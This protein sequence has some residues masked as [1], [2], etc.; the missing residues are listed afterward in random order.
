MKNSVLRFFSM[1]LALSLVIGMFPMNVLAAPGETKPA[2]ES[3]AA[4]SEAA[5]PASDEEAASEGDTEI[6]FSMSEVAAT[7]LG[8]EEV[9]VDEDDPVIIAVETEL[10][11]MTVLND[12]GEAVKLTEEQIQNLLGLYQAYQQQWAEN[13]NVLGAQTPFFLQ[14]NDNGEDGLGA[15]GE[16]LVLSGWTVEE[17]RNGKYTYDDLNGMILNFYYG[18]L[19]GIQY[20][21]SAVESARDAA[22]AAVKNSGAETEAQKLLVLND[23]LAEV[24]TFD[25]PYIMNADAEDGEEPMQAQ[26]LQKH[27][28]EQDVYDT[29]YAVYE[30]SIR[31]QFEQQIKDGLKAEFK[32]QYYT[33]AIE[34]MAYEG[35]LA[36]IK[37]SDEVKNA[38]DA[39]LR[40]KAYDD[41]YAQETA[42]VYNEAEE[43][44]RLA[45]AAHTCE[46]SLDE[47]NTCTFCG[48]SVT[49]T[50]SEAMSVED[51]LET[52]S[53]QSKISAAGD[54]YRSLADTDAYTQARSEEHYE[55]Y[56]IYGDDKVADEY[57]T[58]EAAK[59]EN[60]KKDELTEDYEEHISAATNCDAE[61]ENGTCSVCGAGAVS[62]VIGDPVIDVDTYA[63]AEA[64]KAVENAAADI[65]AAAKKAQE[66]ATFTEEEVNAEI[67]KIVSGVS[68]D[69]TGEEVDEETAYESA[70]KEQA[71][72]YMTE[73]EEAIQKDP[74]AFVESNFGKEAAAQLAAG[75][76]A[77][78]AD[79]EENGVE[80]DPVSAPGYKMTVEE[81]VAQQMDTAMDDLGGMTPNEAIPVYAG[82]A[83]TQM[84]AGILNYWEGTQFGALAE[85][86]SVCLGYAK[87]YAYL[88]Q[89][90]HADY[91]TTDGN[92][93]KASSWKTAEELY[94]K[95]GELNI[96]AGYFVD[97]V[98]ISFDTDVTM[99]GETQENFNSDHFWNAVRVNGT[100]YYV[101]PCYTDVYVEVMIRDRAETDGNVNHLYFMFSHDSAT[102]LYDGYYSDLKT[103][104]AD[105][106][107]DTSYED[108]WMARIISDTSYD[109][110]YVYYVYSSCDMISMLDDYNNSNSTSESDY[111]TNYE[112]KLV[113]HAI[114]G[115]DKGDGDED[116]DALIEF[117]HVVDEETEETVS[118]VYNPKTKTMEENAFLTALYA[119]HKADTEVYPSVCITTALKDKVLY[120]NLSNYILAYDIATGEVSIVKEYGTVS[121]TRDTTEAFGAV[122]FSVTDGGEYTVENHPIAGMILKE[123]G[124]LY[125]SIATNFSY[126]SGKESS[127]ETHK[128]PTNSELAA[129]GK[130]GYVYEESN[131]NPNYS[132]YGTGDYD[133]SMLE[134][135]GYEKETNDNDEFMWSANFVDTLS[136]SNVAIKNCGTH[137]YVATD[138]EATCEHNAYTVN[139][140][141]S[142]GAV[143][144][145]SYTEEA[146]TIHNHH[147]VYFAETYYTKDSN[148]HWNSGEC[149]VCTECGFA[150][151]EPTEPSE[152]ANW[153]E[154]DTSYEEE[155]AKYEAELAI[156]NNA[157]KTAGHTYTATDAVWAED[158]T[159]VTFSNVR[160]TAACADRAETL[161]CLLKDTTIEK[162]LNE[163]VTA[164]AVVAGY[165]GDCTTGATVTYVASGELSTGTYEISRDVTLEAGDH[166]YEVSWN[167]TA[168]EEG[169]YSATVSVKCAIC[170]DAHDD[171]EAEVVKD[172]EATVAPTVEACG[173]DVYRATATIENADGKTRTLT[174]T[175][176]DLTIAAPE[177]KISNVASTGKIKLSWD[178]VDGAASYDVYR[179]KTGEAGSFK[180]MMNVKSGYTNSSTT[181]GER[182]YYYVVAVAENKT[183]KSAD[184]AVVDAVCDLARPEVTAT[185][186]ASSGKIKLSWN[187]VDGATG[188]QVYRSTTGKTG[189]FKLMTT[190]KSG[191]TNTSAKA[192]QRYYYYVVA[193]AENEEA[194]SANSKTVSRM[195]DLERPVVTTSN[196]A[197]SGKIKLT[198]NAVDG[199]VSYQVY[200]STT[201]KDGSFKL[202]KTV[203]G[204][205]RT[206]V[207]AKAGTKYYY[208]VKAVAEDNNANS[209][210]SA[211]K[212]RMCDLARPVVKISR[213]ENGK[214]TMTWEA[215]DGA[216]KYQVYYSTTGEDGSFKVLKT[217]TGTSHTHAKAKAG[218]KYYYKVK[219]IANDSNANSAFSAVKTT[220]AK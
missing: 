31:T 97:M 2:E 30:D 102:S 132:T 187:A 153:S 100:W 192:G 210:F 85:G 176:A 92:Y 131:Y 158:G 191:Y 154:S 54:Y 26:N 116:Y 173:Q 178:A 200:R 104:Y 19:L 49:T 175:K 136:M 139:I 42:N 168:E 43:E 11:N 151:E 190:V 20:Y 145:G 86:A 82:Q 207:N 124:N 130:Y 45:Y 144:A 55:E 107:T 174:D 15:M 205:S 114:D 128:T 167:W 163:A 219:A 50:V 47:T 7:L 149:Y 165:S 157:K 183:T 111:D 71:S 121:A 77:F 63:K 197:S 56:S 76:D 169:G 118:R 193:V 84:T 147:Y 87:A 208:K 180:F 148:D 170:G 133:D 172:E 138:V 57:R 72:A 146:D 24:N 110:D 109:K 18:D 98:R 89:C 73:N 41:A 108:S 137:E 51:Y 62:T 159:S 112:Y 123:D 215:V 213:N 28:H 142:C 4:V 184:S 16:M 194:N 202:Q 134:Q 1:L 40:Q 38:A 74:E 35:A 37:A 88:V 60:T 129:A 44:A 22:L 9:K 25:M 5:E 115:T 46:E 69:E 80:V 186:V 83:A 93:K 12:D 209:A 103:L 188:Y 13:A 8:A 156:W 52:D 181:A 81:I 79:A 91:Y 67:D 39:S 23:W 122:A 21:G 177:V 218:T 189:S 161:D 155:Y 65:D 58:R 135:F 203:T 66:D 48:A 160:C 127:D 53:V 3:A 32:Q 68:T 152:N 113:R 75:W 198:W 36:Q 140:C 34:N 179:S 119:K 90:M 201:G 126:I 150:I 117:N 29:I 101:D 216:V 61:G 64:E 106:A 196:V 125:V 182:Y 94:Y 78:W 33:G 211:V 10:E 212:S 105:A 220:T 27:E 143:E 199:A 195:C 164:E 99:Y 204:T 95:N 6:S 185:N 120:F 96:D 171:I 217:V 59:A 166:A 70:A 141:S 14:Y 206:D 17:V 214:P 162:T